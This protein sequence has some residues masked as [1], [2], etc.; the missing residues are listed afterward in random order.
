M[1]WYNTFDVEIDVF[2]KKNAIIRHY[3]NSELEDEIARR[4]KENIII[5]SEKNLEYSF[6]I[7]AVDYDEEFLDCISNSRLIYEIENQGYKIFTEDEI[8]T[9]YNGLNRK[10]LSEWLGLKWWSTKE[11]VINEVEKLF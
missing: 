11:Q 2:Q 4:K 9:S 7:D 8:V 6:P 3:S 5:E 1:G 10:S